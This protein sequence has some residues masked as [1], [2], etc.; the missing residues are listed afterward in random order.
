MCICVQPLGLEGEEEGEEED[1][2]GCAVN[3]RFEVEFIVR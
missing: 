3:L 1:V 2:D